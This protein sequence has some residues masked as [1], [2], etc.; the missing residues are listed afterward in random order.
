MAASNFRTA[1]YAAENFVESAGAILFKVSTKQICLLHYER[2]DEWLLPKG[3]RNVGESR[4]NTALRE[5]QEETGYKCRLLPVTMTSR[6]PPA[7][8]TGYTPDEPRVH[9]D[10]CEPFMITFRYLGEDGLKMIG[11][12]IA[13]IEESQAKGDGEADSMVGLFGFGKAMS[14]LTFE[15]DRD[16]LQK[17]IDIFDDTYV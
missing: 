10:V 12:F 11:W 4:Y 17:A 1:Q 7:V 6:V 15:N 13:A 5:A 8:E 14:K 16:V 2:K 3:R 9:H